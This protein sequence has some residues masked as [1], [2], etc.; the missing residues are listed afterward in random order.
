MFE[1]GL[2]MGRFYYEKLKR[3]AEIRK[4]ANRLPDVCKSVD[5]GQ[6]LTNSIPNAVLQGLL[7]APPRFDGSAHKTF[8]V[9]SKAEGV[10]LQVQNNVNILTSCEVSSSFRDPIKI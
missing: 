4:E 8:V 3:Q 6:R 9:V 7:Q 2:E 5:P 1:N 10:F